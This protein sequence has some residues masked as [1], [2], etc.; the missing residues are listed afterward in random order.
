MNAKP[1][2]VNL[3]PQ[4]HKDRHK[5]LHDHL[6]ELIAD[7]IWQTTCLPSKSSVMDLMKWSYEQTLNPTDARRF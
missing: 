7:W 3:T 2:N 4:E 6:D 5:L 1:N